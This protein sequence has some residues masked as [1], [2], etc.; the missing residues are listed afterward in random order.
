MTIMW[1]PSVEV[2]ADI[3]LTVEFAVVRKPTP[4]TQGK[5]PSAWQ[6]SWLFE[7]LHQAD[8]VAAR[9]LLARET[10]PN[11][12]R[13]AATQTATEQWLRDD[14][15]VPYI[16]SV[17]YVN[18]ASIRKIVAGVL[19]AGAIAGALQATF[20]Q[21]SLAIEGLEEVVRAADG[22]VDAIEEFGRDDPRRDAARSALAGEGSDPEI[23]CTRIQA[24]TRP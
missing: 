20:H 18:P 8:V 14:P 22:L 23:K 24:D 13:I 7:R 2:G 10:S 12:R 1:E 19:A 16:N 3:V 9:T 21:T 17:V 5:G 15:R 11:Y 4:T 6:L